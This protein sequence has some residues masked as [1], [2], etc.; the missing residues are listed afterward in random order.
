MKL[1]QDRV[2]WPTFVLV[3]LNLRGLLQQYVS[4]SHSERFMQSKL[5]FFQEFPS[6]SHL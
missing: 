1:V 3:A 6:L 5:I 2:L 4:L